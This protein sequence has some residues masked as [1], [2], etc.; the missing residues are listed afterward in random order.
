VLGKVFSGKDLAQERA[1]LRVLESTYG[2]RLGTHV[3]YVNTDRLVHC[4]NKMV[5]VDGDGVLVSSQNWSNA[6]VSENRE[7][8]LWLRHRGISAYLRSIFESDWKSAVRDPG[9]HE[10]ESIRP[11]ALRGGRFVRVMAGDYV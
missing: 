10:P 6:A 7:A 5:L 9:G 11:E 8:G 1:N 4:H 3:R 2:L